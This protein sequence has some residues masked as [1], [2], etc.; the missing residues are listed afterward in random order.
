[1]NMLMSVKYDIY[2]EEPQAPGEMGLSYIASSGMTS[3]YQ[4]EFALPL[5]YMLP[6]SAL[7]AWDTH[8]GTPA[9]AQNSLCEALDCGQC[10][11]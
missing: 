8:A 7:D 3:I 2:S 1:M 9:L 10:A 5:G 6:G 4:T 11:G